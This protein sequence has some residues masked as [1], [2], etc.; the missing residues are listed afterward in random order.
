MQMIF[1]RLGAAITAV[2]MCAAVAMAQQAVSV[3]VNGQTASLNPPPVERAGRVFV[4]LRGV[5]EQL[6]ASV[7][8]ANGEINAQGHGRS[9]SLHIG[10]PQAVVNGQTQQLDVAP[11]I[12]GASTYVPL[13]F[14]AQALGAE[15]NWDNANRIVAIV[16]GPGRPPNQVIPAQ[17]PVEQ[18]SI[19]LD[20]EVPA[21]DATVASERPTIEATFAGGNADPNSLRMRLDGK[22]VTAGAT[23]SP[24]GVVYSPPSDLLSQ[25]H[26]V[27][28]TGTDRRG[29]PFRLAWTFTSGTSHLINYI[30]DLQPSNG[31]SVPGTFTISGRTLPN[32]RVEIDAGATVNVGRMLA[33]GGDHER[34]EAIADRHGEFAQQV[35]LNVRPGEHVTLVVTSTAPQTE[36]SVRVM[37]HYDVS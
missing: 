5:F 12:I 20:R 6:G 17:A 19:R 18:S 8:Y 13:R 31:Q 7:V 3:T 23:L 37:R 4:P 22:D 28:V 33:F 16:S 9:I 32:A 27:V 10:S 14:V 1:S 26:S 11:F 24:N 25:Q 36:S 21:G 15:V 2:A 34:I 30:R 29:R 35:Q